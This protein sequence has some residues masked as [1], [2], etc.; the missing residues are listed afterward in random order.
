MKQK[1][2]VL[3]EQANY[4]SLFKFLDENSGEF[5]LEVTVREHQKDRSV[6][7]NSLYWY[8][9]TIIADT[10]GMTKEDVHFDLKRRIL[11]KIFIRDEPGYGEMIIAV[12][13]VKKE[14]FFREAKVLGRHVIR[15]TSTTAASVKQFAEY[16]TEIERDC[17]SKNI[18]LPHPEDRYY[19]SLMIKE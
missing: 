15:M 6:L 11:S 8:W 13:R 2:F 14:G 9:I 18:I 17:I 12:K 3:R 4:D 1:T 10:I 16:L 5:L 19:E 7:Q